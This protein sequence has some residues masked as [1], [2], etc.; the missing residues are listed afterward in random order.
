MATKLDFDLAKKS[1]TMAGQLLVLFRDSALNS[2][3]TSN[4]LGSMADR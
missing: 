1:A 3:I 2:G 4:T